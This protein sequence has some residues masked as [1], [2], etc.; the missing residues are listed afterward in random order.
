MRERPL[1][2]RCAELGARV[3]PRRECLKTQ[4]GPYWLAWWIYV[5]GGGRL[6]RSRRAAAPRRLKSCY[7]L[8]PAG[9]AVL[10]FGLYRHGCARE[11]VLW[12]TPRWLG[13]S[14]VVVAAA[15]L[16]F[17][18][19]RGSISAGSGR[20]ASAARRITA[21]SIPV[22][23]RCP[24]SDLHGHHRRVD[25]DRGAAGT[26]LSWLGAVVIDARLGNQGADGGRSFC[27]SNSE[28]RPTT[29]TRAGADVG[30]VR[31]RGGHDLGISSPRYKRRDRAWRA[32]LTHPDRLGSRRLC[33]S[34]SSDR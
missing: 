13:A 23:T 16:L 4:S 33:C 15:G 8:S 9:G 24:P 5:D 31:A 14:M 1:R 3:A 34:P 12:R 29:P 22:R 30:L 19:W 32:P 7:R 18:W 28:Q 21:S 20:P 25:C 11:V 27:A 10:L 2:A 17:T 26:L 6:E